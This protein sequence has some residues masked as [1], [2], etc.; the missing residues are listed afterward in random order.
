MLGALIGGVGSILGGLLG[1]DTSQ[2]TK[3]K[4]KS[5]TR[6]ASVS[7]STANLGRLVRASERAGFNPLTV[8]RAG[9]LSAYSTVANEGM[10]RSKTNSKGKNMT[11]SSAPLGAGIAGAF[12][13]IGGAVSSAEQ[14]GAGTAS[15]WQGPAGA[16][17][18]DPVT[19]RQREYDLVQAQLGGSN[20]PGAVSEDGGPIMI[21]ASTTY[22]A[23][24]PA[25]G[26]QDGSDG[27]SMKPTF[28]NPTVTNPWPSKSGMKVD[29][30][31]PDVEHFETRYGEG[32]LSPATIAG[33][34]TLAADVYNSL[35]T[36]KQSVD[37]FNKDLNTVV[38]DPYKR[39]IDKVDTKN[40]DVIGNMVP[41]ETQKA[42]KEMQAVPRLQYVNP[43]EV[44]GGRATGGW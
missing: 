28:E 4:T 20:G 19:A 31:I 42:V 1:G 40:W 34:G 9:G 6:S 17:G 24:K 32:E 11:S 22:K 21:P 36:W 5:K 39:M 35:P 12:Q 10:S 33:W 44:L 25:L 15:A 18:Y 30:T 7:Q 27:S 16:P 14:A 29:P 41:V 3:E 26:S 2:R 43:T 23:D 38:V 13:S 37:Q 8:L